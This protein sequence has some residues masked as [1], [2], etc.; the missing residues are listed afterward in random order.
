MPYEMVVYNLISEKAG[1]DNRRLRNI[2]KYIAE[3]GPDVNDNR[4]LRNI[5]KYIDESGPDVNDVWTFDTVY[6]EV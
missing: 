6:L 1:Y 4:R 5:V 2:V 3:R